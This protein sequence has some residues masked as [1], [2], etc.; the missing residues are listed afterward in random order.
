MTLVFSFFFTSVAANA[1]A[2]PINKTV[3][4]LFMV[5]PMLARAARHNNPAPSHHPSTGTSSPNPPNSCPSRPASHKTA[6]PSV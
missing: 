6:S 2:A 5:R 3:N 4:A 1:I